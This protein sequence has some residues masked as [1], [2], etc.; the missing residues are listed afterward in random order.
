MAH[1]FGIAMA[2]RKFGAINMRRFLSLALLAMTASLAHASASPCDG[3]SRELSNSRK[4][5][6]APVIAKQLGVSAVDVLQSFQL[7]TWDI[8]SVDTHQSDEVFLF[9]AHDPAGSRYVTMW[10]GGAMSDE[11][12]SIKSWVVNNAPGIPEKLASCF[13]W[14]VTKD[15][16]Q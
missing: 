14:H 5:S 11:E 7:D 4:A 6:L 15:R 16:D 10:S 12:K 8:V 2:V 1:R 13:A 3:V 9:Y